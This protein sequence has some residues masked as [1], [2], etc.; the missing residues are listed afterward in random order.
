MEI[1]EARLFSGARSAAKGMNIC[2]T[3]E[4]VPTRKER[5]SKTMS[6]CV[7]ARP[8]VSDVERKNKS[9]SSGRLGIKSPRGA[10]SRRPQAYLKKC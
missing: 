4:R 6:E 2:G 3:T 1:A 9:N 8:I 5:A 7:T 10:I